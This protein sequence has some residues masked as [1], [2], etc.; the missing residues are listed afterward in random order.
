MGSNLCASLIAVSTIWLVF[1]PLPRFTLTEV[2]V[3]LLALSGTGNRVSYTS[4]WSAQARILPYLEG[5]TL[6][7][8][9]QFSVFKEG[10]PN[11]TVIVSSL[12]VF[13]CPSEVHTQVLRHDQGLSGV[14]NHGF[15]QGD[16]FVWGG[17]A[18]PENRQAFGRGIVSCS[19]DT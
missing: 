10:P 9:A 8:A 2:L 1:T 16:W 12:A 6:F 15:C 4:G 3:V 5:N 19:P 17:F 13:L 11:L 7:Q 14:I 18:G